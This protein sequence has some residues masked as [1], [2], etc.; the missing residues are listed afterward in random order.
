MRNLA[1]LLLVTL[2]STTALAAGNKSIFSCTTTTGKQLTVKQIGSDYEFAY[3]NVNFKNPIKQVVSNN[4]SV[5]SNRSGYI[6]YSLDF[7]K[8]NKTSYF[9]QYQESVG[10]AKPLFGGAFLA[11]SNSEP[12]KIAECNV[13]KKVQADFDYKIMQQFGTGY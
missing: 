1:T 4:N 9:V 7:T 2:A 11:K 8:D 6:L 3:D 5:V 12:K 10:D 13:G